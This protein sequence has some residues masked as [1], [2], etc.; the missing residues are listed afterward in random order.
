MIDPV[1]FEHGREGLVSDFHDRQGLAQSHTHPELE[2]NL[3][4]AGSARYIAGGRRYLLTSGTLIWLFPRQ[5]HLLVDVSPHFRMWICVLSRE[6]TLTIAGERGYATMA[7]EDPGEVIVRRLAPSQT[8]ML[9]RLC[10][11]ITTGGATSADSDDSGQEIEEGP[12][13][14]N[15]GVSFLFMEAWKSCSAAASVQAAE[16]LSPVVAATLRR[17]ATEGGT[18][19]LGEAAAEFG[20]SVSWLSRAFHREAGVGYVDYSSRIKLT[21][22][23]ELRTATPEATLMSLALRAGFGSYAQF[24][25]VYRRAYGC[26]PAESVAR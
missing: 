16:Q 4:T 25:R 12:L 17:I 13:R 19:P 10:G 8:Q 2:F 9:A 15:H 20:V 14:F 6:R 21:R 5:E 18:L 23:L 24:F 7:A 26:S 1:A 3:V 11:A 22:F